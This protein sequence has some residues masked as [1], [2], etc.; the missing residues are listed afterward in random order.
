MDIFHFR[1]ISAGPDQRR[2]ETSDATGH[3]RGS[4]TYLDDKGV[5]HSVH[6]IAG[7]E[8]G[9]R[10][11]KNVK[12]PHLPSIYPFRTPEIIPPNFYDDLNKN[13][14]F[15]D[16]AASGPIKPLDNIGAAKP[17]ALK[18][19]A[20]NF[21]DFSGPSSTAKP[22]YG[23]GFNDENRFSTTTSKS[24]NG[25]DDGS[26]T[27]R[28]FGGN[29]PFAA[30][31]PSY[32]YDDSE[33]DIGDLFGGSSSTTR[34]PEST[35]H[36]A[37]PR[38]LSGSAGGPKPFGTNNRPYAASDSRP[39]D[40]DDGSYKPSSESAYEPP[41]KP[42][43]DDDNNSNEVSGDFDL[44]GN[45]PNRKKPSTQRPFQIGIGIGGGGGGGGTEGA[46]IQP[47]ASGSGSA[48]SFYGRHTIV[49]NIGDKPFS[50]PPGVSV[51]AHVQAIDLFPIDSKIPSP[52]EQF[53]EDTKIADTENAESNNIPSNETNTTELP[54]TTLNTK[55]V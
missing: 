48:S 47:G 5:Q 7:P 1:F 14:D 31:K 10:V 43:Y 20:D 16:T 29:R 32:D 42:N 40:Y 35:T 33:D 34:R 46:S 25:L 19:F 51:R 8:I 22:S 3:V 52:S 44:F 54:T 49:T 15:F 24:S 17:G 26:T 39:S 21:D 11:L 30:N 23:A 13:D 55:I 38:P 41:D 37:T 9:Y 50:V 4:Y 53:K 2:T 12:G 27:R 18:P 6:Y 45:L 28:P 36:R